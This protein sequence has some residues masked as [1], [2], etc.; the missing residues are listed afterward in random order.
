MT[1]KTKTTTRPQRKPTRATLE[2]RIAELE[3]EVQRLRRVVEDRV[4]D[5]D[6]W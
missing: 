5:D 1:T 3:A 2:R 4:G 6:E